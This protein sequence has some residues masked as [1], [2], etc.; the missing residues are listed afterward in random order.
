MSKKVKTAPQ[1]TTKEKNTTSYAA[2]ATKS[3]TPQTTTTTQP[4]S[5]REDSCKGLPL[6]LSARSKQFTKGF[7]SKRDLK[8]NSQGELLQ[9]AKFYITGD[10]QFY[11]QGWSEE[12]KKKFDEQS[13]K[14]RLAIAGAFIA[15][16]LNRIVRMKQ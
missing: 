2:S 6:I 7:S 9:A 12:Q 5:R 3:E 4:K 16:E 8:A 15:A 10:P 14:E 1:K 13:H 11:P